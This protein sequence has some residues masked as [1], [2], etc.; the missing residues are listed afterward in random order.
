MITDA[1][2]LLVSS[3]NPIPISD[4]IEHEDLV[5]VGHLAEVF[6]MHHLDSKV[7]GKTFSVY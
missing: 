4:L 5:V 1:A 7:V 6:K 2:S 3:V